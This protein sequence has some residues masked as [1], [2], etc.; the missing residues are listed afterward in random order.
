[1]KSIEFKEADRFVNQIEDPIVRLAAA[2]TLYAGLRLSESLHLQEK[3]VDIDQGVIHVWGE[4]GYY[5]VPIP[6]P[7]VSLLREYDQSTELEKDVFPFIRFPDGRTAEISYFNY[8][9]MQTAKR[10]GFGK[11][12]FHT[13]RR[14]FVCN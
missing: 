1:M 11:I 5:R 3:D 4:E 2:F 14:A 9:V 7:L 13:L 8:A 6:L 10:L 12:N